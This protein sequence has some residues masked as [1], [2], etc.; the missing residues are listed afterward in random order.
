MIILHAVRDFKEKFQKMVYQRYLPLINAS[1][2]IKSWQLADINV[3]AHTVMLK[4]DSICF[5]LFL[6]IGI[7]NI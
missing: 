7:Y 1:L 6:S 4:I 2:Y 5:L 3:L